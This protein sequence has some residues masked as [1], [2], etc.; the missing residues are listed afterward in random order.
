[1]TFDVPVHTVH[2][3]VD[4]FVVKQETVKYLN[5]DDMVENW[6]MKLPKYRYDQV[7]K[8]V[9]GT[10]VVTNV[11]TNV[12]SPMRRKVILS[13][14]PPHLW[15]RTPKVLHD[16]D[17]KVSEYLY[18]DRKYVWWYVRPTPV[19]DEIKELHKELQFIP[20]MNVERVKELLTLIEDNKA[21]GWL[22]KRGW[23][24]LKDPEHFMSVLYS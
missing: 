15:S 1:M 16:E 23:R 18:K 19:D 8:M 9:D 6:Q 2:T 24:A 17:G 14:L 12:V 11:I 22:V 21:G 4:G 3:G 7:K 13:Q 10:E 20:E 5:E